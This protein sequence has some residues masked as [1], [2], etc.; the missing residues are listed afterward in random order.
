[1]S[2]KACARFLKQVLPSLGLRWSGFRK[3]HRTVCK[4]LRRRL[5]ALGIQDLETYRERLADDPS[6]RAELDAMCRIPIS[7]FYR[8][9]PVFDFLADVVLPELA[10]RAAGHVDAWSCGCA[11]GEEVYTLAVLWRRLE[12]D[13]GLRILATDVEE[14]MLERARRG[15]YPPS[16]LKELPPGLRERVFVRQG[17]LLCVRPEF[18]DE[19]ELQRQD[20]RAAVPERHFDLILCRNLVF[21]YFERDLQGEILPRI[22]QRLRPAGFFVLGRGERLPFIPQDLELLGAKLPIF[23][24][25][26]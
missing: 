14:H 6:E 11:S 5:H 26:A 16:S 7:R 9:R 21:T 20:V 19:I 15:C 8:D 4:R 10:A 12:M 1:M 3:V 18:R 22:M 2:D 24:K 13:A 23:R 25:A 17:K